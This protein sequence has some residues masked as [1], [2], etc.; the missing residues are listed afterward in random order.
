MTLKNKK[1]EQ[2]AQLVAK[3]AN[4]TTAYRWAYGG[5][6]S[7]AKQSAQ[8]LVQRGDV[9]ERISQLREDRRAERRAETLPLE[10]SPLCANPQSLTEAGYNRRY[11]AECYRRLAEAAEEAGQM[12]H[13]VTALSKIQGMYEAEV[14]P[15]GANAPA[16][17]SAARVDVEALGAILDKVTSLVAKSTGRDGDSAVHTHADFKALSAS[18]NET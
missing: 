3:G 15:A 5:K 13:A 7:G 12:N 6:V 18:E 17:Q 4:Q 10:L 16:P 8:R 9:A 14:G 11:F 1:H 2:F